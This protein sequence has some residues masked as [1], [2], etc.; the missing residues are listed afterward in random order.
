MRCQREH[1]VHRRQ[2]ARH[3]PER[4]LQPDV[5][6]RLGAGLEP[7]GEAAPHLVELVRRGAL[8]GEDRLLV[9]AHREEAALA[10]A[11]AEAGGELARQVLQ[12]APLRFARVLRLVDEDV[13]DPAVELVQHPGRVRAVEEGA[14][15]LDQVVEVEHAVAH[16][17]LVVPAQGEV[18]EGEQGPRPLDRFGGL[19]ALQQVDEPV[20]FLAH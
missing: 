4:G 13:V 8:E 9:V 14:G 10:R 3:G 6:E 7:G 5:V 12:D 11:G 2:H 20:L 16:L 18:G 17:T 15:A 19:A 1:L